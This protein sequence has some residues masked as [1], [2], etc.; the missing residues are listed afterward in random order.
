MCATNNGMLMIFQVT[1]D[2]LLFLGMLMT[3]PWHLLNCL[4]NNIILLSQRRRR[5]IEESEKLTASLHR[6]VEGL[7]ILIL[8][9]LKLLTARPFV[10]LFKESIRAMPGGL[11]P[12]TG[13]IKL[14]AIQIC[15]AVKGMVFKQFN[16]L[17]DRVYKSESLGLEQGIIFQETDQLL[18]DFSLNL[19][20]WELPLKKI[21]Q[22][23][24]LLDCASDLSSFWK[25]ATLGLGG[26]GE[27][28]LVQG[29]K[30]H[31]NCN[32]RQKQV[33]RL[34]NL[35]VVH[36]NPQKREFSLFLF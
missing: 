22:V 34:Y 28:S 20:N 17:Y 23:L 7:P 25:T 24:F 12:Y 14:W 15:A 30:I 36:F 8:Q 16:L 10:N 3:D 21:K 35:M 2:F 26:F 29:S 11:L 9:V 1:K 19:G 13:H 33:G 27:F 6:Q 4:L 5:A 31:L 32:H 18:E